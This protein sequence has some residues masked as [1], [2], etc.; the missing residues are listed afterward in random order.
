MHMDG[1]E[2]LEHLISESKIVDSNFILYSDGH[3]IKNEWGN[4]TELNELNIFDKISIFEGGT[5]GIA[6]YPIEYD[7]SQILSGLISPDN[8]LFLNVLFFT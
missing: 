3:H 7:K 8:I 6:I 5:V 1:A 4:T 2:H